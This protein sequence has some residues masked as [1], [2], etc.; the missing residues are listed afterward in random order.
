MARVVELLRGISGYPIPQS[1]VDTILFERGLLPTDEIYIDDQSA[2]YL[3]AKADL[4]VWLS[5]APDVSQGGQSYSF[6]DQQRATF[7]E[8]A[9]VLYRKG[10]E[11][12]NASKKTIYGYKGNSF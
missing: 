9:D 10:G 8:K 1:A 3:L 12:E 5:E 4:Y 2:P 7:R 6:T 11:P